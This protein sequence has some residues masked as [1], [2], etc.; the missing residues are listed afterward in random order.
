MCGTYD[1]NTGKIEGGSSLAYIDKAADAGVKK[2][3]DEDDLFEAAGWFGDNLQIPNI[4]YCP[5]NIFANKIA[6][7][8]VNFVNPNLYTP[9]EETVG[10][11]P[12][13][14]SEKAAESI[15]TRTEGDSKSLRTII[16]SWYKAFRNIAIV[17]LLIVLVYI[18]I[19]ILISSTSS[20]KAKYKEN[21]QD[22]FVALCLVFFIHYIM[23]AILSV[24]ESI[25]DMLDDACSPY[26][27]V[28]ASKARENDMINDDWLS[29]DSTGVTGGIRFRT[30]ITG[31]IRFMTQ[32]DDTGDS[33]SYSI[34]FF[35]LTI[36]TV[37]FTISYIKR[38]LY[39]A[40]FTMIAPLV[41]LTYPLDK[42]R[43]GKAQAFNMW[44]KEYMM[45]VIIQPV[46]YLLFSVFIGSSMDLA[47]NNPIY[48]IIAIGFF[49]PAEKYIKKLFGLD[50]PAT[51][52]GLG[53]VAGG[54]LALKGMTSLVGQFTSKKGGNGKNGRDGQD[55]SRVRRRG[56][57]PAA[58]P[59]RMRDTLTEGQLGENPP[60]R[61]GG[62]NGGGGAPQPPQQPQPLPE[63]SGGGDNPPDGGDGTPPD[64]P[65]GGGGGTPPLPD[66][67]TR[68][69]ID[70]VIDDIAAANY[71][72]N[73]LNNEGGETFQN[74]TE[75][76]TQQ[77]TEQ[78]TIDR[79]QA[80]VR[81]RVADATAQAAREAA[82]G[83]GGGA[84]GGGTP[85]LPP[86]E[87]AQTPE[88]R[89]TLRQWGHD[90]VGPNGP[91]W[92]RGGREII[93]KKMRTLK[94]TVGTPFMAGHRA[95]TATRVAKFTAR[96]GARL[97]GAALGAA[98]LGTVAAGA[99]LT[100]NDPSKGFSSALG[101]AGLGASTGGR[102][103][104]AAGKGIPETV[105]HII[106]SD[107]DTYRRATMSSDD[108]KRAGQEVA[109]REWR[110]DPKNYEY[111][112]NKAHMSDREARDFLNGNTDDGRYLQRLR[113]ETGI[114]D[115]SI[116]QRT[117]K[118]V[119]EKGY[120]KDYG[121]HLANL[122]NNTS[123]EFGYKER[124]DIATNLQNR[125]GINLAA[126]NRVIKDMMFV[127]DLQFDEDSDLIN[128]PEQ[129]ENA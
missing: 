23:A 36:F 107:I 45:N 27:W 106:K 43:D 63:G 79:E 60:P 10:G 17:G 99:A 109:D 51:S 48:A 84:P 101:A 102:I 123:A 69:D 9:V 100:M 104:G 49:L 32:V 119:N 33:I 52:S 65:P 55:A 7:L 76:N 42:I 66:G 114:E 46:H 115:I 67:Q 111:L 28:D 22:W 34:M 4:M 129:D 57:D 80:M 12:T 1:E 128:P 59:T 121:V 125:E 97:A 39:V 6:M 91:N 29:G 2:V 31:Y 105:E 14:D 78:N 110:R 13:E 15:V 118:R 75:Q 117:I 93:G 86:P 77:N 122:A 72:N 103:G 58:E 74:H 112:R 61:G 41:A 90:L 44:F 8:D 64:T 30:T 3:F 26:I 127:K 116:L 11:S 25:T 94:N 71:Y 50:K 21:L 95:D 96:H 120:T 18:G 53:E 83:N 89:R 38:F 124:N 40:F 24:T 35:A 98:T 54:A 19:R 126:T 70:G 56:I 5:E 113:K 85:P 68:D 20:D 81:E 88:G 16:A 37:M 92:A 47:A 73:I 108:Y 62:G 87:V 82:G